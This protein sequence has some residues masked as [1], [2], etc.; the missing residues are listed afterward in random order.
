VVLSHNRKEEIKQHLPT[1]L[2]IGADTLAELIIVDNGSNDGSVDWLQMFANQD[3][4]IHLVLNRDNRGVAGGRN[5]GFAV[6]SGKFILFL[7]D[8]IHLDPANIGRIAPIFARYPE[9]GILA[10]KVWDT[11]IRQWLNYVGNTS[12]EVAHHTGACFAIRRSCYEDIGGIDE[13][14]D[15][16]GEELDLSIR[17]H[18]SGW[19]VRYIPEIIAYHHTLEETCNESADQRRRIRKIYNMVRIYFKYLPY[20]LANKNAHRLLVYLCSSWVVKYKIGGVIELYKGFNK[21]RLS[22]IRQ[23]RERPHLPKLTIDHYSSHTL[24]PWF[25]NASLLTHFI[26]LHKRSNHPI[27]ESDKVNL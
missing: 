13:L 6:T 20:N 14:C 26:E 25:G 5:S 23:Y 9:A 3:S 22:G 4:R 16:G 11:T 1:F 8:D 12:V 17:V 15:F 18:A 7:D 24:R 10:F 21:G 2:E 27:R 19:T